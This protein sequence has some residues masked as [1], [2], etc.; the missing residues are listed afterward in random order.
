V[1]VLVSLSAE[2]RSNQ[3]GNKWGV[4]RFELIGAAD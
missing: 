4:I 3:H 1:P 2:P